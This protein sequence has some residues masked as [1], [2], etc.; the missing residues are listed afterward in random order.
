MFQV[1]SVLTSLLL[2][3][4]LLFRLLLLMFLP[5]KHVFSDAIICGN[6]EDCVLPIDGHMISKKGNLGLCL[7]VKTNLNER[8]RDPII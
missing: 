2:L 8:E 3:L 1:L 5:E 7:Y 6:A 4:W